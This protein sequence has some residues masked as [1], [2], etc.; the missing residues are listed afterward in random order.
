M[1]EYNKALGLEDELYDIIESQYD[2]IE[3][4]AKEEEDDEDAILY[5]EDD[6]D[7]RM[8]DSI[9]GEGDEDNDNPYY[10]YEEE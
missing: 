10:V 4:A 7:N 9:S 8:I 2:M 5:G 6:E 1:A 3:E